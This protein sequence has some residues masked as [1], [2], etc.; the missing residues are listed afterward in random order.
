M[1]MM[2]ATWDNTPM[3]RGGNVRSSSSLGKSRAAEVVLNANDYSDAFLAH[4]AQLKHAGVVSLLL[5]YHTQIY[6]NASGR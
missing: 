6:F 3:A 1:L 5:C 2:K 4:V